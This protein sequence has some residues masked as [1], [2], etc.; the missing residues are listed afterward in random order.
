MYALCADAWFHA[1]KRK[2]LSSDSDS[3]GTDDR[4]DSVVV[5]YNDFVK[6]LDELSPSLS[7]SELK[8]YDLLRDQFEGA[9][10]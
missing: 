3:S 7:M 10:K 1:A 6:V 5:E 9:S 8:K 4:A 2:V